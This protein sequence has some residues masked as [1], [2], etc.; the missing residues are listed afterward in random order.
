[1]MKMKKH[2]SRCLVFCFPLLMLAACATAPEKRSAPPLPQVVPAPVVKPAP[3]LIAVP[4]NEIPS[5][6]DDMDRESLE[7]AVVRSLLYLDRLPDKRTF[8]FGD[9]RCTLREMRDSLTTFLEI[10]R[11]T[12]D[13]ASREKKIRETFDFYK[14]PG[15]SDGRKVLFTGYYE[16]ILE[17][18]L[19]RTDSY[20]HPIYRVPDDIVLIDLGKFKNKYQ[21][22]RLVGRVS[23][24][25]VHAGKELIPYYGRKDIDGSG[26][27][28]D[29]N[30]EIAWLS[31]PIDVFFLH[32][33][34]S[35]TIRLPDGKT[36][37][38]SYA[39]R[40]GRAYRSIGRYLV[41]KGCISEKEITHRGIKRYLREHPEEMDD[42][43]NYNESYIFF[44]RVEGGPIGSLGVT[45]TGGRSIATDPEFFPRGALAFIK[46]RKPVFDDAGE[47]ISWTGLSR[48]A[49]N[50]DTGGVIKGPGRVDI[51]C[52]RGE[53]A[54]RTAGSFKEEGDLYFIIK[55]KMPA[56]S[57]GK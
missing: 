54:E 49:L 38:V 37:Q 45:V 24:S 33:Q 30:L 28:R 39:E 56:S 1:M 50:Q 3:P 7:A 9:R 14:S 31:D 16:P 23:E 52:G 29:R 41:D 22:E 35:G 18:S 21:G 2:I 5:L 47:I 6:A 51:F 43:L 34:G 48:F 26:S 13:P 11:S 27:L 42:I 40:N 17:G 10:V 4:Q 19:D 44:R 25:P 20:K 15:R 32:I 8:R 57:M 46:L 36:F 55:K 53:A 12:D